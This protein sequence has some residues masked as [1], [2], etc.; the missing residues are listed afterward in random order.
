MCGG[1]ALALLLLF[2]LVA[3]AFG[4][5]AQTLLAAARQLGVGHGLEGEIGPGARVALAAVPMSQETGDTHER[6]GQ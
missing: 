2:A 4:L 6:G 1:G 5:A 3:L